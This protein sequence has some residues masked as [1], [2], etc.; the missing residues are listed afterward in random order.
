MMK[1]K[2]RNR[3]V[4]IRKKNL[5]ITLLNYRQ[6]SQIVGKI[7]RKNLVEEFIFDKIPFL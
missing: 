1:K 3:K 6:N 4:S 2:K 5:K 7:F